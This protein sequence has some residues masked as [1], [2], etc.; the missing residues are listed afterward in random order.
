MND[1]AS[2]L[3]SYARNRSEE[4]FGELVRRHLTLVY[5]AAL[6]RTDGD[7]HRAKDVAQIVFTAL[8]RDAAALSR[9]AALTGWLY[10]ATRNAAIDLMRA[11]RRRQQREE[12]VHTMEE[13]SSSP[14]VHANWE[15]MRPVLD[16]AMDELD[17]R[18]REAVLLRF[19]EGQPFASVAAALRVNEDTA[20]KRVDRALDKLGAL[21]ARKG[22]TST[23]GALGL[24]L[25]NQTAIAAPAS[26]AASI[27]ATVLTSAGAG[28]MG[29]AGTT[30][31][32]I[33][34]TSKVVTGITAIIAVAAIGSAVYQ[35]NTARD[36]A[37]AAGSIAGERD[38]LRARLLST[39]QRAQQSDDK[40]VAVQ[41]ELGA[42]RAAPPKPMAE[43][44]R[45]PSA[46]SA[47][48]QVDYV[49]AHPETHDA[50]VQQQVLLSKTRYE[51]FLKSAGLS[52]AQ[53][54]HFFKRIRERTGGELDF[55]LALREQGYGVGNLPTDPQVQAGLQKM[56]K[57]QKEHFEQGLRSVLGDDNYKAYQQYSAAIPERNVV[58][59]LGGLL[60]L[61]DAPITAQQAEQLTQILM[62]N[63][64][65]G[66][67]TASPATT[68]NG[69]LLTRQ[70]FVSAMA[71]QRTMTALE[72]HAP[73]T[74]AAVA[75]AE[76]VL[77]P[78]QLAAL[79]QV[80]AQQLA[81]FQLA[82]PPPSGSPGSVKLGAGK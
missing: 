30:A 73:V 44:A 62:Q 41:K 81:Q 1:D 16:A 57:E 34:S 32:F 9:H 45:S 14:E 67:P 13:V 37:A 22:I 59:Q 35:A 75:R 43:P 72:W 70:A 12:K 55:M 42:L 48:S 17:D 18:D 15:K 21:L 46:S 50:Y 54:E 58:D 79:R 29:A 25:A 31:I 39:E 28:A 11:E 52:A 6:R 40:L 82:P 68:L 66:Q 19:F 38:M 80:Q 63:R 8:A 65:S 2:L 26:V 7:V 33:M 51:R 53:Q 64:Y 74:D 4:A 69:T 49:L 60:Y 78:V 10:T 24:L 71:Q 3:E 77:T 27:I 23:G 56:A 5:S 36:S 76:T 47:G 20:R 61:S